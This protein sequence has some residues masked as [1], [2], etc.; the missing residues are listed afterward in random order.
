MGEARPPCSRCRKV[1]EKCTA[2]SK[3]GRACGMN[4]P[5]GSDVCTKHGGAAPQVR[6]AAERRREEELARQAVARFALPI[7]IG[8]GEALLQEVHRSAGM[9]AWVEAQVVRITGEAPDT[10]VRGVRVTKRT[11]TDSGWSTSTEAG[12]SVHVWLDLWQKERRHLREV[13]RDALAAGIEERRVQLA[14]QHAAMIVTVL[15]GV[16]AELD[17]T[18]AQQALVGVVVPKHLRLVRTGTG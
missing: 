3:A 17:L 9:V 12:P 15:R 14:E 4:P 8:P 2:H 6:A 1:H 18:D 16:L 13:C 10:L 11:D 5:A 7:E